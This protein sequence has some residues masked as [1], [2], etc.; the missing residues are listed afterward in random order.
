MAVVLVHLNV[1]TPPGDTRTADEV[2]ESI[3]AAFQVGYDGSDIAP[4]TVHVAL[5]EVVE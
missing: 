2:A 3:L 4:L 5:A 1:E